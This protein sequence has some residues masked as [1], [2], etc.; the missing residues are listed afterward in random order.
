VLGS[1]DFVTIGAGG[2]HE[3]GPE[4]GAYRVVFFATHRANL[5]DVG[6]IRIERRQCTQAG[7]STGYTARDRHLAARLASLER[8]AALHR[9]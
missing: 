4:T 3:V 7:A 8:A 2:V 9:G 5:R 1:A 6:G